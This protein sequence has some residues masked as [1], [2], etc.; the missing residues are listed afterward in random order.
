MDPASGRG[1][2]H[3]TL[4]RAT[5]AAFAVAFAAGVGLL[6]LLGR[7]LWFFT[8]EWEFLLNRR[9]LALAPLVAPHNEHWVSLPILIYRGLFGSAARPATGPPT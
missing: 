3:L 8:D 5:T 6:V 4:A 1:G 9:E 7:G 2:G